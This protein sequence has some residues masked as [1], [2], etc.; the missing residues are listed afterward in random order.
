MLRCDPNGTL[1]ALDTVRRHQMNAKSKMHWTTIRGYF[2]FKD[3]R[4]ALVVGFAYFGCSVWRSHFSFSDF[5]NNKQAQNFIW[6]QA[7]TSVLFTAIMILGSA[8]VRKSTTSKKNSE[9]DLAQ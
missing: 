2:S 9:K 6:D 8:A 4:F 1:M 5:A 3:I 7:V